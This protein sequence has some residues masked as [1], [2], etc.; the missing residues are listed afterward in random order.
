MDSEDFHQIRQIIRMSK[1]LG[2]RA[3]LVGLNPGIISS[4]VYLN[5][6][7]HEITTALNLEQAIRKLQIQSE[8]A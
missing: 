3:V 2:A 4:L 6:Q 7:T 8:V 5:V 1:I